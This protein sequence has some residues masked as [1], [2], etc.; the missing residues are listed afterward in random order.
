MNKTITGRMHK[1]AYL[2][3]ESYVEN[4]EEIII[5]VETD[6]GVIITFYEYI[7]ENTDFEDTIYYKLY[8]NTPV[9]ITYHKDVITIKEP[10]GY[11]N[12]ND[13]NSELIYEDVE[14]KYN[15]IDSIQINDET[16]IETKLTDSEIETLKWMALLAELKIEELRKENNPSKEIM[17]DNHKNNVIRILCKCQHKNA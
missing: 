8:R 10:V 7:D 12:R 1:D 14:F 13:I 16:L 6:S 5:H 15:K 17:L 2:S 3:C 11:S 9:T 4:M